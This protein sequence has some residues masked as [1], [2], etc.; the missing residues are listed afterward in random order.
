VDF[1]LSQPCDDPGRHTKYLLWA[2][3]SASELPDY[4]GAD[5]DLRPISTRVDFCCWPCAKSGRALRWSAYRG[6]AEVTGRPPKW[7]CWPICDIGR[8]QWQC[9]WCCF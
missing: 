4:P 5:S 6:R 2:S 1:I 9:S 8:A 7:R 3:N